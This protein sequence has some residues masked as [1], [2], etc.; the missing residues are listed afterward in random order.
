MKFK[1][2]EKDIL[3]ASRKSSSQ[4][5]DGY[6]EL[7]QRLNN[8]DD[9]FSTEYK[10]PE[11]HLPE[12]LGLEKMQYEMPSD[13]ELQKQAEQALSK[14]YAETMQKLENSASNAKE[15]WQASETAAQ[16]KAAAERQ[17]TEKAH[18]AQADKLQKDAIRRG[19]SR[20][21]IYTEQQK[22]L[23]QATA[24][25]QA[26][27]EQTKS[28]ALS[29]IETQIRRLE[30][31][32]LR[33]KS[34]YEAV[35][36]AEVGQKAEGLKTN[37]LKQQE[38][39]K[40]YNDTLDEKE[41]KYQK[42]RAEAVLKAQNDAWQRVN[43]VI[44]MEAKYGKTGM[45]QKKLELK[46]AS[47]KDFYSQMPAKEAYERFAADSSMQYHLKE[48]YPYLLQYFKNRAEQ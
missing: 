10:E 45:E 47:V 12:S 16:E 35:H 15:K 33:A 20:S 21:S 39:V 6:D 23:E 40:K 24:E 43:N 22:D 32:L 29:E 25:R 27:I 42:A 13:D 48:Y 30:A 1:F 14:K 18:V 11:L 37:A 38:S 8:I 26:E 46:L 5:A 7:L 9:R 17:K 41:A 36:A 28:A 19:L 2:S 44:E 4:A 34:D 3:N 31:E